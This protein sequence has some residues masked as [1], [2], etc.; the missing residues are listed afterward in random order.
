[1]VD[2]HNRADRLYRVD[3][4]EVPVQARDEFLEKV[5]ETHEMLRT[6]QGFMQ[7][8]LLEQS[9]A[10]GIVRIVTIVEWED[11]DA[12][13]NAQQTIKAF[14]EKTQF[15]PQDL[16]ARLGIKADMGNYSPIV[17]YNHAT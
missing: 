8:F 5:Q 1:M 12:V 17:R 2:N 11:A 9:A 14:R 13:A 16:I 4:F 7:D 15:N 3:R 10:E 6:V